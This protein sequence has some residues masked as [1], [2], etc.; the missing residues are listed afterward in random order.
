[1][2]L[3]TARNTERA[4]QSSHALILN[5][6]YGGMKARFRAAA[7][8]TDTTTAASTPPTSPAATTPT[9]RTSA[10][11]A[12][13]MLP[14]RGI[15]TAIDAASQAAPRPAPR[16]TDRRIRATVGIATILARS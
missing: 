9:T 6:P 3:A 5:V 4:I 12:R 15:R 7:D 16:P 2:A 13:L 8:A 1:M 14:R 10:G 11:V